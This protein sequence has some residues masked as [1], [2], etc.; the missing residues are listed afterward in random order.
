MSLFEYKTYRGLLRFITRR[1]DNRADA[2]DLAQKTYLRIVERSPEFLHNPTAYLFKV[3]RNV[4]CDH[5][6]MQQATRDRITFSTE[7]TKDAAENPPGPQ[8][9]PFQAQEEDDALSK[10][11]RTLRKPIRTVIEL[12]C[13]ESLSIEEIADKTGIAKSTVAKYRNLGKRHLQDYLKDI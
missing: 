2:E 5:F 12:S 10:G 4:L 9:S 8:L 3:A 1:I 11:V 7:K 13:N 6:K